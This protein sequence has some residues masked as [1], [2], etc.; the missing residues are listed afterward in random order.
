MIVVVV[1]DLIVYKSIKFDM[2][3]QADRRRFLLRVLFL[4]PDLIVRIVQS[5]VKSTKLNDFVLH[6]QH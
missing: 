6:L 5:I 2:V 4:A 3:E 1:I